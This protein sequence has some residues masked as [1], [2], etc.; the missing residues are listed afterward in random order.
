[1]IHLTIDGEPIEV[2]EGT[3]ILEAAKLLNVHIPTLCHHEDQAVKAVCRICVVEVEGQR[4][5][6]AACSTPVTEGMVVKTAS[7]KVIKARKNIME[8]ILARHPQDCLVCSKNGSCELQKVAKDL[9]MNRPNRYEMQVRDAR[10]DNSSPSI[11]RDMSKCILCNRCVE[12]CSQKQGVMVMAKENRGFDTVVVPPYG[13]LLADTSCVNCGQC[14]QVCPVGALSVHD[15]TERIYEQ[16]DAG[17]YMTVQIAPSVR[18]TLA[19]SLGYKPGTV[20]TGKIV[21]ALRKIGFHKVFDSD[22]TADLTIMEEGTE[23][24]HRMQNHGTLPL[25]TSCCPA[26]VK[27][28]ETYGYDQ[29]DHLSTAKSP[30]QM[31]GAVIKTFFAEKE[32]IDPKDICSVSVMPCTAKK[33]EC[34]RKEFHDSGFQDVDISITVVE[35]AKMIRTAGIHFEDLE[36]Q[37]FDAPFGLG[38][39]AGQIFGSTGGVMEAALRTVY[40]VLTGETLEKLEFMQVRGLEGIREASL[41]IKG[42]EIRVAIVHG[43]KNV[44]GILEQIKAGTSP[45]HFIE[46]MACEGGCIGGGGNA[47][48]T[49]AKVRERQ[50]A[51]YEED[52]KLP[53]RKSHENIYVQKLYEEYL[54]EPLSEKSHKLLH[55]TY[56][57]RR[58][59]LR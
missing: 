27:Y 29:L 34:R 53:I 47:P 37:E 3:T 22:F 35:L 6:P 17:K 44:E 56:H 9:N 40:E 48:K 12:A 38:S 2:K 13:K 41:T 50:R 10:F 5:L 43:L 25:I 4:L 49:M 57:S 30:Q 33:F 26:W 16:I 23:F 18:I 52:Q 31:F 51:I 45:Y 46:V 21:H 19:E 20:T 54:G 15:D 42:Q 36:D 7:P 58:D 24:L 11:V 28:C 14:I 32:K 1:M 8:L 39:G 55:T 59:L